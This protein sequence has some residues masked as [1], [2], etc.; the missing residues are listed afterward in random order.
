MIFFLGGGRWSNRMCITICTCFWR[1]LRYLHIICLIIIQY[2]YVK[3]VPCISHT[4]SEIFSVSHPWNQH[5][6]GTEHFSTWAPRPENLPRPPTNPL[7]PVSNIQRRSSLTTKRSPMTRQIL[8]SFQ[9]VWPWTARQRFRF[10]KPTATPIACCDLLQGN[11]IGKVN[12]GHALKEGVLRMAKL[13]GSNAEK[14]LPKWLNDSSKKL[15]FP[16][17]A[18]SFCNLHS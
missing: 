10:L 11:L 2:H 1:N 17:H 9:S 15:R 8:D 4:C 12:K 16:W 6:E 13:Q 7:S 5:L 14:V 3:C 18:K